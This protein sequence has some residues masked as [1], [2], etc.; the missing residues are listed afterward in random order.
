MH[1]WVGECMSGWVF[2][3]IKRWLSALRGWVVGFNTCTTL[4]PAI[5]FSAALATKACP[6][7][8]IMI[9]QRHVLQIILLRDPFL[10]RVSMCNTL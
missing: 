5:H 4:R 8:E 6:W 2:E 9:M 7:M 10:G 3:C 1:E